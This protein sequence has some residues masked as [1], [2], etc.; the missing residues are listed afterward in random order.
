MICTL[1]YRAFV[2]S[3]GAIAVRVLEETEDSYIVENVYSGTQHEVPKD[4]PLRSVPDGFELSEEREIR[5]LPLYCKQAD[6]VRKLSELGYSD[7]EIIPI[8]TVQFGIDDS[9]A[10]DRIYSV[11]YR[12]SV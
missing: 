11:R 12:N 1:P 2:T 7:E 5:P 6:F 4:F 8:L 3:R 10:R 9:T